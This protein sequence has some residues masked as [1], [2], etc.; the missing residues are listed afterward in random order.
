MTRNKYPTSFILTLILW[1]TI[2]LFFCSVLGTY[3]FSFDRNDGISLFI[4][5]LR[6][7]GIIGILNVFI[8]LFYISK[9]KKIARILNYYLFTLTI[10]T[11]TCITGIN[12]Y[13]H[14]VRN[15]TTLSHVI[16][17]TAILIFHIYVFYLVLN[18]TRKSSNLIK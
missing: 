8:C 17:M 4:D 18:K 14:F 13:M 7:D 3:A 11:Q 15:T 12:Y 10:I 2:R 6:A 1:S 5:I 9:S 16:V